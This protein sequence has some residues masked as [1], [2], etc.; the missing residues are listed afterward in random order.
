MSQLHSSSA[1]PEAD[2]GPRILIVEDDHTLALAVSI[3][4]KARG[5][6][7]RVAKTA[8]S[9]LKISGQWQPQAVLLDLGL[10]DTSGLEVL[11]SLRKWSTVPVIVVSARHEQEGKINALDEG[12]DDY[13][14]KPFSTGELLARLRSALRRAATAFATE[15][16]NPVLVSS[17]SR[18]RLDLAQSSVY[19]DDSRIHLTPIQW[20]IVEYM[21]R[22]YESLVKS[23]DLLQAVWG[24]NYKRETN[25]LRVYMSQ[26]RHKLELDPSR[27]SYFLTE[28]GL[29]YRLNGFAPV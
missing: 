22:N 3:N 17:D 7:V 11:R 16:V 4:L 25:Y 2:Q 18:L 5:Y 24:K 6:Q 14:T 28:P 20:K 12:A 1:A 9:A 21:A 8:A 19:V 10:P 29:G 27:P 23:T 13:V 15:R 26:L